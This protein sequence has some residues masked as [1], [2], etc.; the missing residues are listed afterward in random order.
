MI[1]RA[2]RILVLAVAVL[3]CYS[4]TGCAHIKEHKA[5]NSERLMFAAGFQM[6]LA[7]TPDKLEHLG[8]LKPQRKLVAH[9]KDGRKVYVYADKKF[10]KCL[11]AGNEAAFESFR[12]LAVDKEM[13][14]EVAAA[15]R[16]NEDASLNWRMWGPW[17]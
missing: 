17:W 13:A 11:Y 3:G 14:D 4:L 2:R 8:S 5:M 7:D 16:A 6:K 9:V 1:A 12:K 15:E 10:C